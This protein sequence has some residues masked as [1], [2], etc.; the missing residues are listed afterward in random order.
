M[1]S[2]MKVIRHFAR[3]ALILPLLLGWSYG[4]AAQQFEISTMTCGG[5]LKLDPEIMK[6]IVAWFGGFYTD[7]SDA[8]V[9]DIATLTSS[10]AKLVDFCNREPNFPIKSAAEGVFTHK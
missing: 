9:I 7:E 1:T 3:T 8:T 10:Q 5:F 4:G 6:V 2:A